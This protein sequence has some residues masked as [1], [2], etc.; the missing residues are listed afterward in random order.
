MNCFM[1][2][3]TDDI[4]NILIKEDVVFAVLKMK[5]VGFLA[6][7]RLLVMGSNGRSPDLN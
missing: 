7:G 1:T 4:G 2:I 3:S 6:L 5:N